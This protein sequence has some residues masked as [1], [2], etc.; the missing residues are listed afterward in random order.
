ME[1]Y[2]NVLVFISLLFTTF[3]NLNLLYAI[4]RLFIIMKA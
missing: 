1:S 4:I 2:N 3:F